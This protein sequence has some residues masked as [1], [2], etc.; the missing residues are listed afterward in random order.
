MFDVELT[1]GR[2]ALKLP[3]NTSEDPWMAA[4]NWLEKNELSQM[5]LDQVAKF[6]M[7][8]TKGVTLGGPPANASASDPF[9]GS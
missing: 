7:D 5:F 8:Q 2:P 4:H 9:T 3:Y 6:I 1:E